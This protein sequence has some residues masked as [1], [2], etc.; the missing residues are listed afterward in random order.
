MQNYNGCGNVTM[1][2]GNCECKGRTE[3]IGTPVSTPCSVKERKS[4]AMAY[5]PWQTWDNIYHPRMALQRGTIFADL[6]MPFCGR[7]G[8]NS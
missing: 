1:R 5:V 8:C 2:R 4:L 6:D 3:C 7:G